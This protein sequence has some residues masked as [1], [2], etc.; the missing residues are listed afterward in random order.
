MTAP[1]EEPSRR[2]I[3]R[4]HP[5]NSEGTRKTPADL[6]ES[7]FGG[8]DA[9]PDTPDIPAHGAHVGVERRR[10]PRTNPGTLA[11]VSAGKGKS[12]ALSIAGIVIVI[13]LL[14]IMFF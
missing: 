2:P 9:V 4:A 5:R 8:A 10:T 11:Q 7:A 1:R 13:A 14:A 6:H 12:M 3:E